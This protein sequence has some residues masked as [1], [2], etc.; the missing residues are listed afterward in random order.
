MGL[1][2][3]AATEWNNLLDK[4]Y[5]IVVAHKGKK[6]EIELSFL[7]EDFYHLAGMQYA[8]DVDFGI[9][10]AE[11][12]GELLVP[13]ILNKTLDSSKIESS[14][15]WIKISGRLTAIINLQNTLDNDFKI[16]SF[17]KNKVGVFSRLE[18]RYVIKNLISDEEYFVFFDK[19]EGRYYCKSAFKKE[20]VDYTKNQTP[21]T[22]L[23]KTKIFCDNSKLLFLKDNFEEIK[24]P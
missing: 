17:N 21:L 3:D 18:A 10:K 12:Y 7:N 9:N 2:F 13:A 23:Q 14:R 20:C 5:F 11:Y 6:K 15:N 4:K 16:F 22:L 19:Q 24:K 1:F 8:Q